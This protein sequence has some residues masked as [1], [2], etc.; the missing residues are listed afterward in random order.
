MQNIRLYALLVLLLMVGGMTMKAQEQLE[1]ELIGDTHGYIA[2][3]ALDKD[4]VLVSM[5]G[6]ENGTLALCRM[7]TDG[8]ELEYVA[9]NH[10][11][12]NGYDMY[13]Y[14][15][16]YMGKEG[17]PF[18]IFHKRIADSLWI[19][20]G[21]IGDNLLITETGSVLIDS[22]GPYYNQY[23]EPQYVI[24][25]D[26]TFA[27]SY[28]LPHQG[29]L[30]HHIIRFDKWGN[31]L[32]EK[33]FTSVIVEFDRLFAFNADSTGYLVGAYDYNNQPILSVP[34]YNLDFNLDTT[35]LHDELY[36]DF[37]FPGW[38]T[39][40]VF[41]YVAKHPK[42]GCLYVVGFAGW[43][44][45]GQNVDQDA[46]IARYDE[47]MTHIDKWA[48]AMNTNWDDQRA[49]SKSIDFFPDG[50]IAMCALVGNGFYV[51]RFDEDLN[52]MSE[53]FVQKEYRLWPF[54]ICAMPNGDCLVTTWDDKLYHILADSFWNVEETHGNGLKVAI[55]YPNPGK[56]VFNI[57]TTLPKAHVEIYDLT[58]KLI[59]KKE[60]TENITLI[61]AESWPS[62]TY[63]WKVY[64][65]NV[66]PSTGSGTLVETGKWIKQ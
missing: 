49:F 30:E 32:A 14:N 57:R 23:Q 64:T 42:S 53:I 7:K 33:V 26:S 12:E 43:N 9:Q 13:G 22:E 34:C 27:V 54:E 41:P 24:E 48:F 50:S 58:G 55:A 4:E 25:N 62:G 37:P 18:I 51:A 56:D 36:W 17:Q 28:L 19:A 61:N 6:D 63:I 40:L 52:K 29:I 38:R 60:I 5:R 39:E 3:L 11:N 2:M 1:A 59:C 65:S 31:V 46:I 45:N 20:V 44:Y 8:T 16:L 47:N 21:E 10:L 35:R 15:Y 66:G